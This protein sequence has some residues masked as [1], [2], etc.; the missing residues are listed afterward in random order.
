MGI[1]VE[2]IDHVVLN[3][4]DVEVTAAWYERVLGMRR[5]TFG[6][7]A[8]IALRFGEQKLNLRPV[9]ALAEDPDWV[10]AS[11]EVA[12]SQDLCF[13]TRSNPDEVRTHLAECGAEIVAGPVTRTGA[14]GPMTSHYCRD[15]DGNLVEIAVYRTV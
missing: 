4:N 9:G 1:A 7:S 6:R 11:F 15:V 14:L 13:I 2:R 10:T 8:R 5:E 12:G 3:C